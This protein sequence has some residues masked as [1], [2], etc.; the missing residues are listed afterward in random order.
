MQ[1]VQLTLIRWPKI[2]LFGDKKKFY[3]CGSKQVVRKI[4]KG[5]NRKCV[6]D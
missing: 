1:T 2:Q 3:Q 5:N 4:A 6:I